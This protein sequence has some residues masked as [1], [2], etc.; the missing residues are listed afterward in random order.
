MLTDDMLRW[1]CVCVL[2]TWF[3]Y[4]L[5]PCQNLENELGDV[6]ESL[7]TSEMISSP[8]PED[9]YNEEAQQWTSRI[10]R[11]TMYA[12]HGDDADDFYLPDKEYKVF[13]R[14]VRMWIVAPWG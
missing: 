1:E 5:Q 4:F 12:L 13:K 2:Y 6:F 8:E 11:R 9:T 10:V 7:I 3:L 14:G